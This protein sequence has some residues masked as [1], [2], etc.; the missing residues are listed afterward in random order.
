MIT[1]KQLKIAFVSGALQYS[2]QLCCVTG[3][4]CF[5]LFFFW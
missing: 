3:W 4:P 5:T 2:K 1:K